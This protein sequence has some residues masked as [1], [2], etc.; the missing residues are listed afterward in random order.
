MFFIVIIFLMG[1]LRRGKPPT[2]FHCFILLRYTEPNEGGPKTH[3]IF[4]VLSG[5]DLRGRSFGQK[6]LGRKFLLKNIN[7]IRLLPTESG[8]GW[9]DRL[10]NSPSPPVGGSGSLTSHQ[11]TRVN[12]LTRAGNLAQTLSV[13]FQF[14]KFSLNSP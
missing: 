9:I 6:I 3:K 5:A 7:V 8:F 10:V 12:I 2:C 11:K 4:N 14:V 13:C 1:G